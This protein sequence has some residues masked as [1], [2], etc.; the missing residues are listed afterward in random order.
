[1]LIKTRRVVVLFNSGSALNYLGRAMALFIGFR[2]AVETPL[3]LVLE[4]R[5]S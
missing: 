4:A 5:M 1:M 3:F 2:R